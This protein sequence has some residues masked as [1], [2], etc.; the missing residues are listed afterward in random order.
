MPNVNNPSGFSALRRIDGGSVGRF[1]YDYTIAD[2]LAQNIGYGNLVARTGSGKDITNAVDGVAGATIVGVFAGV[3]YR[4]VYG[5]IQ[6]RPNWISGT[7]TFAAEGAKAVVID[8][9]K[10]VFVAQMSAGFTAT[11]S[12]QFAG[13]VLA[14]PNSLGVSQWQVNSADITSTLDSVKILG[15]HSNI[16][17]AYGT[18]AKVEVLLAFH[19]YGDGTLRAS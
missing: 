12:G 8:D 5:N 16:R 7:P 15:L 13:L 4:D 17:N 2:A 3:K 14:N 1:G 18:N 6:Y 11:D 10:V 9:P 19:E